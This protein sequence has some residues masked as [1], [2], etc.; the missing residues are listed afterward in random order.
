MSQIGL[1][2][3]Q[4]SQGIIHAQVER[5]I[6]PETPAKHAR[7]ARVLFDGQNPRPGLE[8]ELSQRTQAGSNL[9][10]RLAR[11]NLRKLH[12][13]TKLVGI[14]KERLTQG[15]GQAD[16]FVREQRAHVT[17]RHAAFF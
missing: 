5:R 11:L 10:N 17:E 3:P 6:L 9:E 7:E 8:E 12:D 15:A 1:F 14:V 13:A 4:P 2:A 16:A